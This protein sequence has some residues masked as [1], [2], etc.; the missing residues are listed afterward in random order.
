[1][2]RN[3]LDVSK[4]CWLTTPSATP[5]RVAIATISRAMAM[6]VAIGFWT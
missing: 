4:R 6:V 1:V 5:A 2:I 3:W